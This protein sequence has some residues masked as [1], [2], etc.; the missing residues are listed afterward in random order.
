MI[1]KAVLG[2]ILVGGIGTAGATVGARPAERHVLERLRDRAREAP[3]VVAHRG[4]SS[5][6][7][8]NTILA[9]ESAVQLTADV[10]ELDVRA[11]KDGVIVCL[12]DGI[13][14]RTTDAR[15]R[16]GR[17][18]VAVADLEWEAIGALDAGR[19]RDER[20]TGLRVPT[21]E[22]ALAAIAPGAVA[23]IERK[24]GDAEPLVELLR[25]LD[26]VD[27]VL[28]QAFDWDYLERIRKLEPRLSIGALGDGELT[29]D[30]V[31]RLKRM[32]VDFVHW[33][34]RDLTVEAIRVLKKHGWLVF[35]YT[36]ND[37]VGIAGAAA[38]GIDG[39]T[40]DDPNRARTLIRMGHAGRS[41]RRGG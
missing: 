5:E 2:A 25:R 18:K 30:H 40:T 37:D 32:K 11:S 38:L 36:L 15:E 6:Y 41:S 27:A 7:P 33:R 20:F 19:W 9:F 14:D 10:V 34:S 8:E 22:E 13:L 17:E 31:A 24:A 16:L 21:L 39:V 3:L 29:V 12:H 35:A 4:D 26:L 23:M 1:P 28:V